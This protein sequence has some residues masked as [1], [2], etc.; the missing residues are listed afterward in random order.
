MILH[1]ALSSQNVTPPS[2]PL[3]LSVFDVE[4]NVPCH[5]PLNA[6]EACISIFDNV[7]SPSIKA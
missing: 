3:S 4:M 1:R 5:L 6:A 2:V 7:A